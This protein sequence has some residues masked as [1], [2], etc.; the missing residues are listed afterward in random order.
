MKII[1]N[2]VL[3]SATGVT[4]VSV[5][6]INE[7]KAIPDN[8]YHIFLSKAV[9]SEINKESFPGNFKFYQF[10]NKPLFDIKGYQVR[11]RL[12]QLEKEIAPDCVFSVFGPSI[13]TPSVPHLMG[14]AYPYYIYRDSPYFKIIGLKLK[15]KIM[16]YSAVHRYYLKKNGS[17]YVCETMDVSERLQ[18]FLGKGERQ[19]FTVTNTFNHFY[20]NFTPSR[21]SILPSKES[22][23]FRFVTLA[24]FSLHKNLQILNAV[25]PLL[26][27]KLKEVRVKFILTG[28]ESI[29]NSRISEKNRANIINLG[30][31]KVNEC[32]QIYHE[33]DAMFLPSL[34]E[35]FSASYAESMRMGKPII[36]S[37]LPFAKAVCENAA[38]YFDPLDAEDIV[39]KMIV[40]IKDNNRRDFLIKEGYNQLKSFDTPTNRAIK[41]LDI[42]QKII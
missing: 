34:M 8:E 20:D 6:F 40:I 22:N 30:R 18:L 33:S 15:L 5:S 16:I 10:K 29:L 37:N 31:V 35:C 39:D 26:N 2:T 7:C 14:Y 27:N 4:Q 11:K 38:L 24:S 41:Y 3:L 28:D 1:V 32:P 36:T 17:A 19:I 21:I 42:C 25:I 13:W 23:E 9:G 12:K